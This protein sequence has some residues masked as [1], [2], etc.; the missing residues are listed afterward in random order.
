MTSFNKI[1]LTFIY[2]YLFSIVIRNSSS[3]SLQRA[4]SG[5]PT[6]KG[7]LSGGPTFKGKPGKL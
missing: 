5:D 7:Y 6:S 2:Y 1:I 3:S 4:F